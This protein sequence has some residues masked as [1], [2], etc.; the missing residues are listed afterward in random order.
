VQA[1]EDGK[2]P[3]LVILDFG[4]ASETRPALIDGML[5]ILRGTFARDDAQV[6][7][8]I[9]TM[10]FVATGG[11]RELLFRTIRAYFQKLLEI[12]IQDFGRI[13]ADVAMKLA[14]PGVKRDELRE[15]MKSVEYPE[16]WF[17]VERAVVIIFGLCAQ[18]APKLNTMQVGFPYIMKIMA[19]R[20]GVT[21]R[22]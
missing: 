11:D 1:G 9:E 12:D 18:L 4:A 2:P 14:D 3:K 6:I 10:G 17:Y 19:Q 20:P 13:K 21:N 7:A 5:E 22:A 15:L 16:G 8:G